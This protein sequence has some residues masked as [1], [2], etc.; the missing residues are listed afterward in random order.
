MIRLDEFAPVPR[1]EAPRTD[2]PR[3]RFP[4]IDAHSHLAR[5]NDPAELVDRMDR[6]NIRTI[7][8]MDGWWGGVL[9]DHLARYAT[10][11]PGRFRVFCRVDLSAVDEPDFGRRAAAYVRDC[12]SKG[13]AGIKFSKSL[14]VKLTD[15]TG[16]FLR[17]DDE[18]LRSIWDAAARL[19]MPV[20]IHIADPVAFFLPIDATNERY[21]ELAA[22]PQWSYVG[23]GCP[24]FD[25]LLASQ[26]N[27]LRANPDTTFVVAHVGSYAE[28]LAAVGAMLDE[29]PNLYVDTAERIA[30][31]G[32][33][34][35]T[36]RAF[37]ER[38]ADRVLYG[39]DLLPTEA[40]TS[41][42]YRFFETRDEYFP[43]NSFAEHNQ[44]RWMIYGVGLPDDILRKIYVANAERLLG[45]D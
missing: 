36:A 40:N 11:Y 26:R 19:G 21:E 45:L 7:V 4:A 29:F 27:L 39:T 8:D 22:H 33:Q 5:P 32:R 30:E 16:R 38:Y 25:E 35:Y 20:T 37:L 28:N 9:E 12:R 13:A 34:P 17:P 2:R 6:F 23:R 44:G 31:L 3:A 10:R 42:N 15:R 14:G 1:L 24:G 18:R 43:Y 41:A